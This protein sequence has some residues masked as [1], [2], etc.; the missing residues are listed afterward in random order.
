MG[1]DKSKNGDT[2]DAE[3]ALVCRLR[4]KLLLR[5]G[6]ASPLAG[7]VELENLSQNVI[8][9]EWD[10]HPLQHLD[11]L[12]TDAAESP[13]PAAP[14]SDSFSPYSVTPE[15]FRLA[16]G[17][18]YIH[19]VGLLGGVPKEKQLPGTYTVRAVYKYKDLKAVS[20]PLEVQIPEPVSAS[21]GEVASH[22][23][24]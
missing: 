4:R 10:M 1:E 15:I 6:P 20:E 16:P 3:P 5:H 9:I 8:E 14:Y 24:S 13:V 7:E 22:L 11:L 17:E 23:G 12:I 2:R 21:V 18:K 19:N